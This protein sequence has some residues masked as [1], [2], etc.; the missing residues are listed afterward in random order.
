VAHGSHGM[1]A[2]LRATWKTSTLRHTTPLPVAGRAEMQTKEG[3]G[4]ERRRKTS[5]AACLPA[6]TLLLPVASSSL[7]C[8]G[9][10]P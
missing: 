10:M 6:G 4:S 8:R 9:G 1:M 5:D 7:A 3:Q 2:M